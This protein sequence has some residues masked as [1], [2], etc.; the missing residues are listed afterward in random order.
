MEDDV[1]GFLRGLKRT[2]FEPHL[3]RKLGF[4]SLDRFHAPAGILAMYHFYDFLAEMQLVDATIRQPS[5]QVCVDLWKEIKNLCQ[6][7]RGEW[8]WYQFLEQYATWKD[9]AG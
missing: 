3:A 9:P 7:Q 2:I 8:R 1:T 5:Q 6:G 4:L